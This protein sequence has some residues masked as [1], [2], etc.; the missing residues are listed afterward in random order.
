[1]AVMM[2]DGSKEAYDEV[3]HTCLGEAY[4]PYDVSYYLEPL[5]ETVRLSACEPKKS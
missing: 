5:S 3:Q 2:R 4:M 1:M